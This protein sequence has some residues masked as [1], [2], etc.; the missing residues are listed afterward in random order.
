MAGCASE[1]ARE[2]D[3][4]KLGYSE[5]CAILV[6]VP[7]AFASWEKIE[8]RATGVCRRKLPEVQENHFY[9]SKT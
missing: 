1:L 9:H 5:H 2:H 8:T 7:A 6:P 4:N 3:E